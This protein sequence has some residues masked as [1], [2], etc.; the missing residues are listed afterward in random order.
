MVVMIAVV[1]V[2]IPIAFRAPPTL[3]FI[4]PSVIGAPAALPRFM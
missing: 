4:P 1:I 3:V 2:I